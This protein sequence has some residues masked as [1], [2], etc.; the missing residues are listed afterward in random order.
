MTK[1]RDLANSA[2]ACTVICT[3]SNVFIITGDLS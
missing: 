2:A 3:V 1:A